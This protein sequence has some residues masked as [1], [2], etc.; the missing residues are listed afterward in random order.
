[1]SKALTHLA[2]F[3]ANL[4][5]FLAC[6]P[7]WLAFAW[8][9]RFPKRTQTRRLRRI[10]ELA[11]ETET[12]QRLSPLDMLRQRPLTEYDDYAAQIDA[13]RAGD[14][15]S[16]TTEPVTLLE[17]T[18]GTTAA[19]KL[20]PYT[21][22]LAREF[23]H[24]TDPWIASLYLTHPS[25]LCGRHYWS[26]SPN[27][28]PETE[29]DDGP[30]VGFATDA[31]YLGKLQA[32]LVRTLFAVPAALSRIP[33]PDAFQYVTLLFLLRSRDLRMVSVWHPSFFLVL[34]DA[35]PR[36]YIQAITDIRAGTVHSELNVP[37]DVHEAL[38]RQCRPDP[39]RADELEQLNPWSAQAPARIWPELRVLSCWADGNAGGA[40]C[41]LR[42]RLPGVHIQP[43]GL[44]ATEGIVTLPYGRDN[45]L[46]PAVRSHFLEFIDAD[47]GTE[48][49]LWELERG[50]SY[51]VALST[52]N[53]LLRYQL[54]DR[55]TVTGFKGK[56]PCLTFI[57]KDNLVSDLVG[58]KL[59]AAFVQTALEQAL[60]TGDVGEF[61]F[62]MLA[63][64]PP[65]ARPPHYNLFLQPTVAANAEEAIIADRLEQA[66]CDNYHYRHARNLGQLDP[67]Q[68]FPVRDDAFSVYQRHVCKTGV[69][70]GDVKVPP[71]STW[72][73]WADVFRGTTQPPPD[74]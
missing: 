63:P 21:P 54:H 57:G 20:I 31:E 56:L 72:N 68:P 67:V 10:L 28:E 4:A 71:L 34:I 51:S 42:N 49:C 66:L 24:A 1:M 15:R 74:A 41:E 59:S 27:T 26:I 25:L 5:W 73:G 37:P 44:V 14:T 9:A 17:P 3:L 29:P 43:K 13:V 6:V 23:K 33:D 36:W 19:S 12:G 11:G 47:T 39:Q 64:G 40:L 60:R 69:K 52:G 58:E 61:G 8:A 35:L 48:R 30:P 22:E 70:A 2:V 18:S 46:V 45:Q 53:G 65:D 38:V 62:L 55:V 32:A 7:G 16:L 50:R